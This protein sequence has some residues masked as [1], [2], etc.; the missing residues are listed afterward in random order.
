MN[1]IIRVN[2]RVAKEIS[3]LPSD[4]RDT[5]ANFLCKEL[6]FMANPKVKGEPLH[7]GLKSY[8]KYRFGNYRIICE[9]KKREILIDVITVGDRKEV[10]KNLKN[11]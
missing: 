9:I 11:K 1:W 5:I 4:D 3:K 7:G 10:Y 6:P 2:Q 8:W